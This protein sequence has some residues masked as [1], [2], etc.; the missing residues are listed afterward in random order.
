MVDIDSP[1]KPKVSDLTLKALD[2]PQQ[3]RR[4]TTFDYVLFTIGTTTIGYYLDH[5]E[6]IVDTMPWAVY[7]VRDTFSF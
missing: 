5:F 4:L 6:E 7:C 3:D 1:H 2:S